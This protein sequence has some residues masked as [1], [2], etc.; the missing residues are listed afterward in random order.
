M[1]YSAYVFYNPYTLW[2]I[3]VMMRAVHGVYIT[4]S[5]F[6]WFFGQ[7]IG[8]ITGTMY[9]MMSFIYDPYQVKQIENKEIRKQIKLNDID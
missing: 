8:P 7:I 2:N 4:Y 1:V 3:Y 5:F 6:N 9:Y